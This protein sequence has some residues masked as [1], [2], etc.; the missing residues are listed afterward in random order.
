M[1][2]R[3]PVLR[4]LLRL[5][6]R[7]TVFRDFEWIKNLES[8]SP[9][10][11]EAIQQERLEMLL[12]HAHRNV[13]Y[14]K[15]VLETSGTMDASGA[16]VPDRFTQLPLLTKDIL[17]AEFERLKSPDHTARGSYPETSGG[18]TGEPVRF[19]RDKASWDANVAGTL[20]FFSLGGKEPGER[21]LKLWGSERDF[22]DGGIGAR[23]RIENFLYNRMFLNSFR[24]T[25]DAM[26]RYAHALDRFRPKAVWAYVDSI[27]ELARHIERHGIAVRP[28]GTIFVTAGTLSPEVRECIERVFRAPVLNQYGS[29]EVGVIACECPRREGLHIFSFNHVV[30]ILDEAGQ[31]AHPGEM[32]RI[33]ITDLTNYSMPMIR[34]LIGDTAIAAG[35]PCSCGRPFPLIKTVTGR[36]TDHFLRRDGALIHGEYFTH[37]FYHRPWI[38][39]FKVI[40]EDYDR[41]RVLII[42]RSEE[43][44]QD[45]Q[46]DQDD[47]GAKIRL[48]MGEQCR[49]NIEFVEA[50]ESSASGKYLYTQSLVKR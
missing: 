19:L 45:T 27:Y 22:F 7:R 31:P 6:G 39:K 48:L 11:V 8:A 36:I 49:V 43:A 12:R 35:T 32:G 26:D 9:S 29:R 38:R 17:R 1:N 42:P 40:Q 10:R 46:S 34:F 28:P 18:S 14:Y 16:F 15:K 2:W 24:M 4:A 44:A 41:V 20:F 25:P 21:E 5:S 47:I 37:L 3:R 30:E 33:V 23:Q 13:P 50:I